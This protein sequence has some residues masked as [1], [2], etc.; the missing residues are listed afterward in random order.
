[1]V[2][3]VVSLFAITFDTQPHSTEHNIKRSVIMSLPRTHP[4]LSFL[5]Y[6]CIGFIIAFILIIENPKYCL[7]IPTRNAVLMVC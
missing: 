4:C 7:C 6:S 2:L 3:L 5:A 1:M